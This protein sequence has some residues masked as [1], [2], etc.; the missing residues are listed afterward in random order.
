VIALAGA[1]LAVAPVALPAQI[2]LAQQQKLPPVRPLG[3]IIARSAEPLGSV[4]TAV[5]LPD[6]KVLV[7]DILRRRVVMFDSTLASVTVVADSTSATANA[8]GA[9]GGGLLQWG[10]DSALFVD[11][12]SL[13]MMVI[14]GQGEIGRVMAVPR[15][16]EVGLLVGGPNGRPGFDPVG[17][18]VYR[19]TLRPRQAAR[20][21]R[22][23]G[24]QRGGA[25]TIGGMTMMAPE[26]PDS[27]I[28]VRVDLSTRAIDTL[29]TFKIQRADIRVTEGADGRPNIQVRQN[30][31]Q[32]V[33]D[34]ALLSDGSIALVRGHD[35]SIERVAPDGNRTTSAKLPFDWQRLDED[36]KVALLDSA[37]QA[38][39]KQREEARRLVGAGGGP[40]Q[41]GAG[42]GP[43]R[44]TIMGDG[45]RGGAAPPARGRAAEPGGAN[46]AASTG[47][48]LP[49]VNLVGPAE[50]P[51]YRPPFTAG[52]S[53]GD[54]DGNLWVRTSAAVGEQGPIYYVIDERFEVV[55]RIQVPQGRMIAGFGREN[56]VYLA[57]R[58]LEGNNRLEWARWK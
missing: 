8:Y 47:F 27:G 55:D 5:P 32:M 2:E 37:R 56:V 35:F 26:L 58:D 6:G 16:N 44:V 29:A 1:F 22:R 45:R 43:E 9:R 24:A 3:P 10:G 18:M 4:S 40:L 14:N 36:A 53:I 49:P 7:N 48:T 23:G 19:G 46:A 33:D 11:P 54:L 15:P 25:V 20:G 38:I 50:L 31:L 12:V 39:E 28:V 57:F 51:D 17:R 13:S 21:A 41:G 34:W 42:G 30:P 52:S